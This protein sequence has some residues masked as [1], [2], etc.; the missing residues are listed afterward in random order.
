MRDFIVA[1]LVFW[2]LASC[3]Y[4]EKR[5]SKESEPHTQTAAERY[6]QAEERL[7]K[8]F[9]T[10]KGFIVSRWDDGSTEHEGEAVLWSGVAMAVLPCGDANPIED[11]MIAMINRNGGALVRFEPLGEYENGR[12]ITIDGAIGLYHGIA[13]RLAHCDSGAKWL[14]AWGLHLKYLED[15]GG[16]LNAKAKN[17]VILPAEFTTL[18]DAISH[19]L[20]MR[21]APH[22]DRIKVLELQA[23]GWAAGVV[24]AQAAAY[25]L[26]LSFLTFQGLE[27]LGYSIDGKEFC[28]ASKAAKI[29]DIDFWCGHSDLHA[30]IKNFRYNEWEY[31]FQR[32]DWEEADGRNG[33]KTPALD[34][35]KA[36]T[37]QFQ[38]LK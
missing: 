7:F 15:H 18:R 8:H 20:E 25:R 23:A 30:F 26:N 16:K 24:K 2:L 9:I 4:F 11:G 27:F 31:R 19:R 22:K 6:S 35:L 13:Y 33:L 10:D 34:Y 37:M 28:A 1:S 36:L 17:D 32:G 3:G 29:P 14:D 38:G 21:G 12:E 5:K